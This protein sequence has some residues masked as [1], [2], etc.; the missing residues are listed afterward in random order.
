MFEKNFLYKTKKGK[1]IVGDSLE[2]MKSQK[3]TTTR[4]K[5]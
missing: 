1:A 4:K 3:V 5:K 2:L